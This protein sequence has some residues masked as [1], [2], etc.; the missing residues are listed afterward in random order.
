MNGLN[1]LKEIAKFSTQYLS[2][3][4][5]ATVFFKKG[6]LI[7]DISGP[8]DHLGGIG[9]GIPYLRK[10]G[11]ESANFHC[12]SFP[13]HRDGELAASMARIIAKITRRYTVVI[14]GIHIPAITQVQ[15]SEIT[16]KLEDWVTDWS[17]QLPSE[18]FSS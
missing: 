9:I 7:V 14:F 8:N 18:A 6:G 4:L 12:M 1:D 15:L 11:E 17:Q 3:Q 10:N 16:H 5:I 13:S 2:H